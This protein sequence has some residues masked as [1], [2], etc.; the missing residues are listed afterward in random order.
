MDEIAN[1]EPYLDPD[2][3]LTWQQTMKVEEMMW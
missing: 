3:M 2:I 1:E